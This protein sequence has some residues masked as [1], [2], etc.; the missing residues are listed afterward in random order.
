MTGQRKQLL[1]FA[2]VGIM[3]FF[4][5]ISVS[6]ETS[7]DVKGLHAQLNDRYTIVALPNGVGLVPRHHEG[8]VRFI[9]VRDGI[10][11]INGTTVSAGEL[12][13]QVGSDATLILRVTYLDAAGLKEL[14]QS[15]SAPAAAPVAPSSPSAPA[16]PVMPTAPESPDSPARTQVHQG[17]VV[18]IGSGVTVGRDERVQGDVVA[19]G[20]PGDVDGEVTGDVVVIGAPLTLGPD[21]LVRGDAVTVGGPL[22]RAKGARILGQVTNVAAGSGLHF[23]LNHIGPKGHGHGPFSRGGRLV[24]IVLRAIVM[25]LG[26][27]I[28]VALGG[29]YVDAIAERAAAEP[30]RAGLA[31]I[32]TEV[33]FVP[34]L[35]FT[36]IVLA[37][38]IIGIPLLILVPFAIVLFSVLMFVG[39]TSVA[40]QIGR[41]ASERF[42]FKHGPY[43]TVALG[44]AVVL[45]FTFLARLLGLAADS[46]FGSVVG[47]SLTVVGYF[48]E[49]VVWTL[50]L[51][52]IILAWLH[53][54]RRAVPP[55]ASVGPLVPATPAE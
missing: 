24:A 36:V 46:L 16:E 37:V 43:A 21:A 52:A 48:V 27:L 12:R 33:L 13:K 6:G 1:V 38:S 49:Y 28:V 35:V 4:A 41:F 34:L 11:A 47:G 9:E 40:C 44:V 29:R 30:V 5:A 15:D 7:P 3:A 50:G 17:D 45:G 19:I 32:L 20:G 54:R 25:I 55:A 2:S 23:P 31:G 39:F 53:T 14:G 51:G 10:V 26:A 8:D 22:S 18:Q 42:G